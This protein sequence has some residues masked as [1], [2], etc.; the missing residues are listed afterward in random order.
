MVALPRSRSR[1][2]SHASRRLLR[3]PLL[4][5]VL[6][7]AAAGAQ[8]PAPPWQA[9]GPLEVSAG[10]RFLQ[11]RDGTPFLW[12]GD[13]AWALFY[14]LNREEVRVYLDDRKK[15]G[16][17][18]IQAV[19]YW[20]P[21]GEDGPGPHNA[22]NAYGHRPFGGGEDD[23]RTR[24]PLVAGGGSADAPNDYWD[25]ADFVVRE[26]RRRGMYLAL[27]PCWGRAFINA[28][29]PQSRP[30]LTEDSGRVYGRFLGRRYRSEPH[31]V[32][33]I[34]GDI[35]PTK[36][37][38]DRRAVYRALAE[39]IGRGV[40]GAKLRWDRP[41]PRWNDLLM[42]YHPDGDP[43]LNSSDFFH[44]DA[45]LD[46][47]GIETWRSTDQVQTA[48]ERDYR[49]NDPV[50]PTLFLEGA[51]EG[52]RYPE[53]G[54]EI[55]ELKARR[56]AW[57]AML[58]GAAGH[59]YGAGS[60]WH[61]QRQPRDTVP[62]G[63]WK[64]ALEL[65]GAEQT[66]AI[67][68]R[69][70]TGLNWWSLVPD[71]GLIGSGGGQGEVRKVAARSRERVVVYFPDASPAQLTLSAAAARTVFWIRPQDA[72]RQPASWTTGEYTPPAGWPDALLVIDLAE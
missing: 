10:K 55:T 9:H 70:L 52:G 38:G 54:G 36:G 53:P 42:T 28:A 27:L 48:V 65:P 31:I 14:K 19:A 51:Y 18:V 16:F 13:T 8:E 25:H 57:Q 61:F 4:A 7:G 26:I 67:L 17:S 59:T 69:I 44:A 33:V 37:A 32:W 3:I 1:G 30:T 39:G 43:F 49:R 11:H 21:H 72:A 46:A 45:W 24:K 56:Q 60:M 50:K 5:A 22:P 68:G 66:A 34:G 35:N 23:P 6:A 15:Q 71:Q 58:S 12:L 47:N 2:R 41:H 64:R 20:Y 63:Q 62:A 29:M 40:T